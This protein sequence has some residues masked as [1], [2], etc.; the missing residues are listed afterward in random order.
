MLAA[1]M[2]RIVPV[3]AWNGDLWVSLGAESQWKGAPDQNQMYR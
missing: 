3:I 2:I 1:V